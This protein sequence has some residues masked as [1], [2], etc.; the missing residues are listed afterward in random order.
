MK[1]QK[2]L[3]DIVQPLLKWYQD[4]RRELPWRRDR[5]AYHVWISEIMLQQTKIEA[6]K[7]Y[8]MEFMK[9]L[10]T[11]E[12]LA[13]VSDDKLLKLWE[14]LGYYSRA[15][16][17]KKSAKIIMEEFKGNIPNSYQ[18]LLKLPGIGEYTAGAIASICYN[19]KVTAVDGNVMRVISRVTGSKKDILLQETKKEIEEKLKIIMPEESGLFNEALMELGEMVCLPN[20]TPKCHVCPLKNRCLA[21]Q[22][23]LIY[24]IPVRI[25]KI[26]RKI[27][28]K[29]IMVV[30]TDDNQIAIEKRKEKGLLNGMYQL[31][32]VE[33]YYSPKELKKLT[34]QW[35]LLVK[36]I[37]FIGEEKHA[38][39]HI[40]WMMKGYLIK[41]EQKNNQF[42]W[43]SP[44][45]LKE[46]YPLPTVFQ[47]ILKKVTN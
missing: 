2:H 43:V 9:E 39:T 42:L 16:N 28:E 10:P 46:V 11:V 32:N 45:E 12:M 19:E 35:K 27:E 47:K 36:E 20:G 3:Q 24:E 30:I 13:E 18:Q 6:V 40:D 41:V 26:K 22:D 5:E 15:K 44:A 38:F 37:S 21:Y 8:Y 1:M 7:K 14:G 31:P 33:G 23:N 17:L 25:N 4:N 34:E 29:T